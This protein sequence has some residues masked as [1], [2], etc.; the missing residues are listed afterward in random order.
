MQTPS[1][2]KAG[3]GVGTSG[4]NEW[5]GW[6]TA[7]KPSFEPVVVARK[8]LTGTVAANVLEHGTGA[9]N[10]DG[11]RVGLR[12]DEDPDALA[13]RSGGVRGFAD[14]YVAGRATGASPTDVSKGR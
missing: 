8:P 5:S 7:L 13:A 6:G 9:L 1:E 10:I 2:W 14:A 12:D 3:R 4:A 11:C